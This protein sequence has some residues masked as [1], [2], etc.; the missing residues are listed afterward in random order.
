MSEIATLIPLGILT[1]ILGIWPHFAIDMF[2]KNVDAIVK[3]VDATSKAVGI[4]P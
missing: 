4:L 1:I 2:D 3:A